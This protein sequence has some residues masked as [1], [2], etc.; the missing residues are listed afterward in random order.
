MRKDTADAA[1]CLSPLPLLLLLILL[2]NLGDE[3][4]LQPS[5]VSQTLRAGN[6]DGR[7][8]GPP[9]S[10]VF[11]SVRDEQRPVRLQKVL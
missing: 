2:F 5:D 3:K 11:S 8:P 1:V 4:K 10:V 7:Q 6:R 9:L